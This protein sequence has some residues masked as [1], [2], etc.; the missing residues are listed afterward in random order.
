MSG[1]SDLGAWSVLIAVI[2]AALRVS[3]PYLFVSLGETITELSGRINLGLEGTLIL[4]AVSGYATSYATGSPWL[5]VVAAAGT[6]ASSCLPLT[7]SASATLVASTSGFR[8]VLDM[9]IP[10][11]GCA[12]GR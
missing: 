8:Q 12:R 11:M 9:G 2:G 6:G 1:E 4:G 10:P 7:V 3:T 5:G